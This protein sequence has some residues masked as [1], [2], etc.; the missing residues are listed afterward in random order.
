MST[1]PDLTID[2]NACPEGRLFIPSE[3][4]S[5]VVRA[6]HR[7]RYLWSYTWPKSL[8]AK[9]Q[10]ILCF[11]I[12]ISTR[13]CNVLMPYYAKLVV[14]KL[15]ESPLPEFNEVSQ[16]VAVL[17]VLQMLF[18]TNGVL[19]TIH[20]QFLFLTVQQET[21]RQVQIMTFNHLLHL[22]YEWHVKRK[23]GEVLRSTDRGA[24]SVTNLLNWICFSIGPTLLDIVIAVIYFGFAFNWIFALL[25]L[26]CMAT[27]LGTTIGLT[28]WRTKFRQGM[29]KRDNETSGRAI[30]S[31]LNY[32]QV[33]ANANEDYETNLYNEKIK[34]LQK[35]QLKVQHSLAVLNLS[36]SVVMIAGSAIGTILCIK[37]VLSGQFT[38]GDYVMFGTYISQLYVPLNWLGTYYRMIQAAFID[39]E[40]LM[41]LLSERPEKKKPEA[42]SDSMSGPV[43]D[44]KAM[45]L[46]LENVS[47]KYQGDERIIL[48]NLSFRIPAGETWALVGESGCGK[49]TISRLFTGLLNPIEGRIL[50]N[51]KDLNDIGR[52][53]VRRHIGTVSQDCP[54][55]NISI[56]ENIQYSKLN[57]S[58][59][60]VINVAKKAELKFE[61]FENGIDSVVG[62]RGLAL[63]GGEKQRVAIARVLLKSPNAIILDEATSALGMDVMYYHN[64]TFYLDYTTICSISYTVYQIGTY[65]DISKDSITESQITK[66]LRSMA[67]GKTCLIIA[68]RLSTITHADKILLI[69]EGNILESGNHS[70]LLQDNGYYAKLWNEQ[71]KIEKTE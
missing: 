19:Q 44:D 23:T 32:E 65:D 51:G 22:K 14:D 18:S 4:D 46:E 3:S 17:I 59:E 70:S 66:A 16:I 1:C 69:E 20:R 61:K 55:F 10:L 54:L 52:K 36:Q 8:N 33:K 57:T 47:F 56:K 38:V 27:Y 37:N 39:T 67:Q 48:K 35:S 64:G 5:K 24:N 6:C 31:L 29:N 41:E 68:H 26:A 15:T 2:I 71:L 49:S 28:E 11:L 45:E 30:D 12:M 63:S 40:N 53:Q 43:I 7:F 9:I 21:V 60:Q 34:E 25:V 13:C 42:R 62:E 58:D 50:I